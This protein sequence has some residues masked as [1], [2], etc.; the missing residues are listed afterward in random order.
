MS[1]VALVGR[2]NVGKSTLFNKFIGRRRALVC[3]LPGVTR[4][5][6]YGSAYWQGRNFTLV[7]T[8]G[9]SFD[10]SDAV[11]AKVHM[12]SM[13]ALRQANVVVCIFDV[14][15]G[16]T[17]LDREIIA[18]FRKE[19]KNIIYVVNK[20]DTESKEIL[21]AE[22]AELGI[23]YLAIS[24]EH[25]RDLD[26]LLDAIVQHLP[27]SE[28]ESEKS[29]VTKI[30]IVG[31]PNVGKSSLIN[32]LSNE[33][34]VIA[35]GMPGTTRDTI[36]VDITY[37]NNEYILVDTAGIKKKARTLD[38]LDKF[39][40]IKSIHAIEKADHVFVVLDAFVGFTRQDINLIAY[41]FNMFKP[42]AILLNKWDLVK[43]QQKDFI[44]NIQF[45][46]K[47]LK[48]LPIFVI[49]AKTGLNCN[50]IFKMSEDFL[51]VSKQRI[52]TSKLNSFLDDLTQTQPPSDYKGRHV[53]LNYITQVDVA[54]PV[55]VVFT[56]YPKGIRSSYKKYITKG[57][58]RL[59]GEPY[60]PIV[61]KFKPKR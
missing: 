25:S 32:F 18:I 1:I 3:D 42:T 46:L 39:A 19:K 41:S 16:I 50:N 8:G 4:D 6:H 33:D 38:K 61:L 29:D 5:R 34:R 15:D 17:P 55:F 53:Q 44:K 43:E 57:L 11:E 23:E 2:P 7:D 52:P 36:N 60:I 59:I 13:E 31:Q 21:A 49:S 26:V 20:V 12:Q 58:R 51:S 54:P 9:L 35:H 27:R 10:E 28:A 24:A 48:D 37:N 45:H 14:Q 30:A 22:F 56:N 47:D 40:T